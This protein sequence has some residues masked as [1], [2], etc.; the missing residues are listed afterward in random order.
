MS[1]F[2]KFLNMKNSNYIINGILLAAVIVLFILQFTGR[3]AS[4]KNPEI[5]G[6]GADSTGFHLPV[7]YIQT[8]S[9]TTK[10]KFFND[11]NSAFLK[12]VEDKRLESNRKLDKWAKDVNDF[13]QKAQVNA[14]ISQ[15][16]QEQEYN[17]L[18]KQK[19]DLENSAMQVEK[20]LQV[21]QA[22]IFQQV[23]DTIIAGLKLFNTPK[24]Y[25]LIF[26]NAGTDN[27]L[28]ADDVYDITQEVTDFLNARYVPS[29]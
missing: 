22:K 12:K 29:K 28:Y 23:T 10:Y 21:E 16:R 14:Y 20:E 1:K 17:K 5:A 11:L 19:Q 3:K 13:Q 4:G 26:S 9:L 18:I 27:I 24:K 15:E 7:A 25:Q 6:L 8:D 2:Y